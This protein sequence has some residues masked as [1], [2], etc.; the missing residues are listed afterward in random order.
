MKLGVRLAIGSLCAAA[1]AVGVLVTGGPGGP[2]DGGTEAAVNLAAAGDDE[3]AGM[4]VSSHQG[5]VDWGAAWRNG[6]RFAYVK[7]TENTNYTNPFF[8]QQYNGSYDVGMIRG[9]YHFAVPN[10]TS[11]VAQ[12]DYFVAHGGGWSPDGR[13]MPPMLD[14][15]YNPY[16]PTCYGLSQPAMVSWIKAFSDRIHEKTTRWP[17][18]YTTTDWWQTC[19]GNSPLFGDTHPLFIARYANSAGPLPSGWKYYT[20]WQ[21]SDAGKFP[22]DQNVFNGPMDRLKALALGEGRTEVPPARPAPT[23]SAAPSSS[24]PATSAPPP[25][26]KSTTPTSSSP[27]STA[28]KSSSPSSAPKTK[29]SPSTSSKAAPT[30]SGRAESTP[31]LVWAGGKTPAKQ[32]RAELTPPSSRTSEPAL[33]AVP[34]TTAPGSPEPSATPVTSALPDVPVAAPPAAPADAAATRASGDLAS[35]GVSTAR[36]VVFGASLIVLGACL[37]MLLRMMVL[38]RRP[39]RIR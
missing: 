25:G 5:N 21:Y 31:G 15:E 35:T 33:V 23:T 9:A 1:A 3:I 22:G 16:G 14:I 8:A 11:A 29:T 36:T 7:A 19:T 18:I 34:V 38:R 6:A 10:A 24:K 20:L 37:L 30:T 2:A 26:S 13:T 27:S 12:A 39:K 32:P 17:M 28:P 4:D